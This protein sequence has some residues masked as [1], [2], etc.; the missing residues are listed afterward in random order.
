MCPGTLPPGHGA[1]SGLSAGIRDPPSLLLVQTSDL[2]VTPP[3][4][5]EPGNMSAGVPRVWTQ[6]TFVGGKLGVTGE[7]ENFKETLSFQRKPKI[8]F[9]L[10]SAS[11]WNASRTN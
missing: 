9:V 5:L 7:P 2:L 8:V 4:F 6:G 11:T 10:Q 1:G 3:G